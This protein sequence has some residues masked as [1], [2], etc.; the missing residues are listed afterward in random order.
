MKRTRLLG[1]VMVVFFVLLTVLSGVVHSTPLTPIRHVII[2]VEENH[3]FDNVFGVY[4]F[5]FPQI[6]NNIT[7]SVMR[8]L[9]YLTYGVLPNGD[10]NLSVPMVPF[11]PWLGHIN[12]YPIGAV[13][14][15]PKEGR[16]EYYGDYWFG[17][18]E[19]FPMYSG[20]QSMG[21]LSYQVASPLWDYAEEYVLADNFYA[22]VMGLTEPNRVADLI[23]TF[24]TFTSDEA[25]GVLPFSSTI[26]YQ[27]SQRNISWGYY[28]YEYTNNTPWPLTAFTGADAYSGHYH[29]LSTLVYQLRNGGL[30][31]VSWAMFLGGGSDSYDLHPPNN[32]T[33]GEV[34]LVSLINSVMESKYWN[35]TVIFVTFDE[36]GGYY[37][38][39]TPP[40]LSQYGLGQRIP[41]LI[42]SPYSREAWVNNFTMS[43][44]T[45]LGFIDYNWRLPYLTNYVSQSDVAGMLS[46]FNFQSPRSPIIL[47]PTNWTYPVKL[48]Y[49]VHYGYV[50]TVSPNIGYVRYAAPPLL[51]VI[52]PDV[53]ALLL[54]LVP[55]RWA[56]SPSI[57]L[58]IL[59]LLLCSVY[60]VEF[61]LYS[62]ELQLPLITTF[63]ILGGS[64]YRNR[65]YIKSLIRREFGA[66]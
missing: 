30:P 26:M 21:Y 63:L 23:G 35:S 22:P 64:L 17:T 45:I 32:F 28:V 18:E 25:T 24:P 1:R 33:A 52:I 27:L 5:G 53:L 15:D 62:F 47:S 58:S 13:S 14:S 38:Q 36:G 34:A 39:V 16:T 7:L 8:P 10:V 49:P 51:L 20:T 31:S 48:Q 40:A 4:P 50:A 37:D 19:G 12:P 66:E 9:N 43:G 46:S 11:L 41:L 29:N 56:W 57:L 59:A 3:S 55:R 61:S 60:Y 6:V 65:I 54:I 44:F 2:V 42:I